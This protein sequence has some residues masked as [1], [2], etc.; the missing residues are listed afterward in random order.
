M[1]TK[2]KVAYGYDE[3][4]IDDDISEAFVTIVI[5]GHEHRNFNNEEG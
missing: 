2:I 1:I 4:Y 3:I 5:N